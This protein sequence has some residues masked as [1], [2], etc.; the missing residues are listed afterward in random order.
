MRILIVLILL[1]SAC[2]SGEKYQEEVL[3]QTKSSEPCWVTD[4]ACADTKETMAVLG[5]SLEFATEHEAFEHA[6]LTAQ[7]NAAEVIHLKIKR[8]DTLVISQG[9]TTANILTG[10]VAGDDATRKVVEQ[11]LRGVRVLTFRR[12]VLVTEYGVADRK[13]VAYGKIDLPRDTAARAYSDALEREGR[14]NPLVER[15]RERLDELDANDWLLGR[16]DEEEIE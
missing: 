6:K 14:N 13:W 3:H 5:V 15:A 11:S 1:V 9:Q 8:I 7:A 16:I 4:I 2:A 10:G 12:L